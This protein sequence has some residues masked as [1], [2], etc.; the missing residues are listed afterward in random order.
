[1]VD[2]STASHQRN[3]YS[4]RQTDEN[5]GLAID[6]SSGPRLYGRH[7]HPSRRGLILFPDSYF[8][9]RVVRFS[10]LVRSGASL[11]NPLLIWWLQGLEASRDPVVRAL[12][13]CCQLSSGI[14]SNSHA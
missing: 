3:S 6:S 14:I 5:F 9:I 11:I 10:F 2:P 4:T 8:L 7:H 13:I 1:M 12:A